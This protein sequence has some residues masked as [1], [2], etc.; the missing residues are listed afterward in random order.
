MG[1]WGLGDPSP[2]WTCLKAEAHRAGVQSC[3]SLVP[4]SLWLSI[5]NGGSKGTWQSQCRSGCVSMLWCGFSEIKI[6]INFWMSYIW[7]EDLLSTVTLEMQ[8]PDVDRAEARTRGSQWGCQR[9][10]LCLPHVN[11]VFP[12]HSGLTRPTVSLAPSQRVL[13]LLAGTCAATSHSNK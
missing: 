4:W 13:C 3:S 7:N 8:D 12:A 1:I 10:T 11:W 5:W 2:Q 6:I 9:P